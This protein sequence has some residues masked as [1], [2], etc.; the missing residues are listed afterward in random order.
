MAY[1]FTTF[2]GKKLFWFGLMHRMWL[3][4]MLNAKQHTDVVENV[5]YTSPTPQQLEVFFVFVLCL[6]LVSAQNLPN[7]EMPILN[8]GPS[9]MI[10]EGHVALVVPTQTLFAHAL[11]Q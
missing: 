6:H 3:V 1:S 5:T 8:A 10:P 11:I 7:C 2:L 4:N 9:D